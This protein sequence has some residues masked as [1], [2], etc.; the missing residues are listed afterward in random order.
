MDACRW[1]NKDHSRW[2]NQAELLVKNRQRE[3]T[4]HIPEGSQ[5]YFGAP[6]LM[7]YWYRTFGV[8]GKTVTEWAAC[9][10]WHCVH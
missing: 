1:C 6:S 10:T 7:Q 4:S 8:F 9:E 3:C 2:K 5:Q